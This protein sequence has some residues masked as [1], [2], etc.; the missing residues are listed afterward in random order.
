MTPSSSNLDETLREELVAY[1]DGEL[2]PAESEAIERRIA[3]DPAA[4][5]E[6]EGF[7][8]VW[9]ALDELPRQQ[10]DESF[11]KSTIEMTALA[12]ERE[13]AALTAALPIAKRRRSYAVAAGCAIAA[14]VAFLGAFGAAARPNRE[15]VNNLPVIE[16]FDELRA[17]KDFDFL[18]TLQSQVGEELTVDNAE[19]DSQVADWDMTSQASFK[20]RVE[21]V[22]TLSPDQQAVLASQA[23]RFAALAPEQREKLVELDRTIATDP[24]AKAL[25]ATVLGYHDWLNQPNFSPADRATIGRTEVKQIVRRIERDQNNDRWRLS[26]DEQTKLHNAFIAIQDSPELTTTPREL[27]KSFA[28]LRKLAERG[29]RRAEGPD[30]RD[31]L[32]AA[33]ANSPMLQLMIVSRIATSPE[34]PP[35][36]SGA[37]IAALRQQ[38][39]QDWN[40]IETKLLSAL[41][42]ERATRLRERMSAEDR[43][44]LLVFATL[45]AVQQS[46]PRDFADFIADSDRVSDEELQDYL[47][48]PRDQMLAALRQ[49]FSSA[50]LRNDE[51]G[52]FL[53]ERGRS[54]GGPF[55]GR[56]FLGGPGGPGDHAPGD[57]RPRDRGPMDR[58]RGTGPP[59]EGE[60]GE[61]GFDG[62]GGPPPRG[63]PPL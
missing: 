62:P 22:K 55:G 3:S 39:Q 60:F 52:R 35:F 43:A 23:N 31:E 27:G 6:L 9:N 34:L 48:L 14:V 59:P 37:Q 16:H 11:T 38:A 57:R 56:G 49:D 20:Q 12:A 53:W 2:P 50:N 63:E 33:A 58:G 44:R 7:D 17:I 21:R 46:Q 54:R 8:R 40:S 15:L 28:E 5:R 32:Q 25:R 13:A 30:P 1:L 36:L 24:Q 29:G 41:T 4:R 51:F 42:A 18:T 61:P 45:Q 10:V 19:L 47:A 26:A